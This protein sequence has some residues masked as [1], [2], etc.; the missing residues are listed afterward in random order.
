MAHFDV[1]QMIG[2]STVMSGIEIGLQD[3]IQLTKEKFPNQSFCVVT[4]WVWIDFDAPDVV[5]EELVAQGKK[6]AMLLVFDVVFDSST[7]SKSHWFRST[8][9][10]DFTEDLF[11]QTENKLYVLVG[12]GRRTSMSL[13]AVIRLF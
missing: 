3:A 5:I 9:L 11:F 8:P 12:N 1:Q 7:T 13:S 4:E 2:P 6:T 10:I